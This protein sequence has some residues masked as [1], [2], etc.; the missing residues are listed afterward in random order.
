MMHR[1]DDKLQQLDAQMKTSPAPEQLQQEIPPTGPKG[2]DRV[3]CGIA[4]MIME[5]ILRNCI[6][7]IYYTYICACLERR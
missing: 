6:I 7:Y 1:L 2:E 3:M 4:W 5:V